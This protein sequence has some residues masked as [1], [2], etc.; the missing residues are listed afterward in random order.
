MSIVIPTEAGFRF[1]SQGHLIDADGER[2]TAWVERHV[3]KDKHLAWVLGNFVEADNANSNGHIFALKDL[4][5][6]AVHTV[7]HKPL[8][9]L[10]HENYIVGSFAGAEMVYP[11]VPA[12]STDQAD[13]QNG[14]P[15]ME[16][17]AAMWRHIYPDEH[18]MLEKAQKQGS[19][20]FSME[21][22]AES[23]TFVDY[24]NLTVPYMGR[25]DKSY[26]TQDVTTPRV[27]NNPHFGGGAIIIPPVRPG[28]S[29]ADIKSLDS[30]ISLQPA[31]S[32]SVFAGI[33]QAFPHLEQGDWERM[34]QQLVAL[35]LTD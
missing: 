28:W 6:T 2:L 30:F 12:D 17:L 15:Y 5:S 32:E 11:E 4:E 29:R 26:P 21:A 22:T 1:A 35:S 25:Q 10:H 3:H 16:A 33:E 19:L 23:L 9:M 13:D 20:F 24:D 27:L 18:S 34:M 31:V 7:A 8:N 14:H